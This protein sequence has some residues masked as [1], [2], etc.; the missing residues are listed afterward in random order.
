MAAAHDQ[1]ADQARARIGV[2]LRDKWRLCSLLGIGGMASV[3]EAT[4]RNGKR[5]AIKVL[6]A[7][8]AIDPAVKARFLREGY[9]ANRVAHPGAVSVLDDDTTEDGTA[10]LVMELL[11]GETVEAVR[12]ASGGKLPVGEVLTI[13]EQTLDVLVAAHAKKIVHR[14]IKPEN[15]FVTNERV[16]KVLDFGIARLGE[17]AARS[18]MTSF[19]SSMGTLGFMAPEQARGRWELVDG[20]TDLWSVG[21]TLF[22]LLSGRFVHEG[23][24]TTNEQILE[25][26]TTPAPALASV[27]P[28]VPREIAAIVDRALAFVR[29]DRWPDAGAMQR[30]LREAC[31]ETP[32]TSP[33][34]RVVSRS[35]GADVSG[36]AGAPTMPAVGASP[37]S[38]DP[39]PPSAKRTQ[40]WVS[41]ATAEARAEPAPTA[42]ARISAQPSAPR[43]TPPSHQ[44]ILDALAGAEPA[45]AAAAPGPA[46]TL[47]M[48]TA[49]RTLAMRK[50]GPLPNARP[51]RPILLIASCAVV[52]AIAAGAWF[53]VTAAAS[54][55]GTPAVPTAPTAPAARP[56]R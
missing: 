22:T 25:A 6:H 23:G 40:A 5:A 9:V 52:A 53:A 41:S 50:P 2:V 31:W 46:A 32:L 13:A 45:P 36:V 56:P 20:R 4:H 17:A 7:H 48:H 49:T 11:E 16:L 27:V 28:D 39:I 47:K 1:L 34:R 15:L 21:A 51:A 8:A 44:D 35:D 43:S 14:D 54:H 29:A 10:F 18:P 38:A 26:M 42:T 24:E 12:V 37:E 55:G 33:R 3:Y 30:A 19:T